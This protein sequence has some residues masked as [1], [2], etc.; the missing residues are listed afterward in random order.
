[1]RLTENQI[2][3]IRRLVQ[4]AAGQEARV[5]VFGSRLNDA[6]LGCDLDLLLKTS[7]SEGNA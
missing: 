4:Q 3:A 1:M 5:R 2:D 6:A 7:E